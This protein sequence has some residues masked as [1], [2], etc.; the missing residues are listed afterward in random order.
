[1]GIDNPGTNDPAAGCT[2]LEC[3]KVSTWGELEDD[4][5]DLLA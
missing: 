3:R 2:C 5:R 4:R 1:M